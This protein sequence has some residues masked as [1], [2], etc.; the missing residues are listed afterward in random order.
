[1]EKLLAGILLAALL[2]GGIYAKGRHDGRA[3]EHVKTVAAQEVA[4]TNKERAD[5]WAT[6]LKTCEAY[7]AQEHQAS[8]DSLNTAQASCQARVDQTN[9]SRDALARIL[10]QAPKRDAKGCPAR[11]DLVM[12]KDLVK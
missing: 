10:A 5:G 12:L 7:R 6:S 3:K 2:F 9:R 8:V 1:M 11:D 4:K